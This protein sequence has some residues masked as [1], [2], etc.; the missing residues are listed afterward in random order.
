MIYIN[1]YNDIPDCITVGPF[2]DQHKACV[3]ANEIADSLAE[4]HEGGGPHWSWRI[5]LENDIWSTEEFTAHINEMA[6][7][8]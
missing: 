2:D 7:E 5:V 8:L 1:F 3:Y 4:I 6:E